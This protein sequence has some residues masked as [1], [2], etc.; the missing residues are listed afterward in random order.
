[1]HSNACAEQCPWLM[2]CRSAICDSAHA[3]QTFAALCAPHHIASA[4]CA[5]CCARRAAP[6]APHDLT[7]LRAVPGELHNNLR[8]TWGRA[9]LRWCAS[10]DASIRTTLHLNHRFA[11]DG[12]DPC[13]YA[14]V[15]WAHGLFDTPKAAAG[16]PVYGSLARRSTAAVVKRAGGAARLRGLAL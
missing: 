3:Y 9:V 5:A 13:S 16:T 6:Q 10:V 1:M 2:T 12:C 14:G 15:L 4:A 11:L 7:V 8:M